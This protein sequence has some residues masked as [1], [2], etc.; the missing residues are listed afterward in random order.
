MNPSSVSVDSAA[1]TRREPS[2]RSG[3]LARF[4]LLILASAT[5]AV[6]G[7]MPPAAHAAEGFGEIVRAFCLSAFE[8][9]MEQAGKTPPAG[10]AD[11]ACGCMAGKLRAGTSIDTARAACRQETSKRYRI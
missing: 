6:L 2:T 10:M 5:A 7:P 1:P 3:P 4:S 8:T 11:Y 9:E